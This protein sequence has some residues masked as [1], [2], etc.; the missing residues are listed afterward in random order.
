MA[1]IGVALSGGGHRAGLFGL[2]ALLY[3]ADAG[4]NRDVVTIS[5]VSGGSLTNA[6]VGLNLNYPVV[7][8]PEFR[9]AVRPLA[10]RLGRQGTVLA[11]WGTWAYLLVLLLALVGVVALWWLPLHWAWRL[12]VFIVAFG[13]WAK[14]VG[15][16]GRVAG[17][18][19]GA[20]LYRREGR[21]ARLREMNAGLDHVLCATEMHV[22]EHV[23]FSGGFVCA[24]E[25]GWGEPGDL[26]LHTAV[27][28]S[29]A[30]PGPFPI[31]WMSTK[32]FGFDKGRRKVSR[33]ALMDGGVYD[34]MADQ[35][36]QGVGARKRRW[37]PL[38]DGLGEPEE[39]VVVN[40]SA[41]LEWGPIAKAGVPV[42]GEIMGLLRAKDVLY[43][44]TTALRRW[45][46][47]GR[48]DRA[49]L[50]RRGLRGALVHIPRSP[51]EIATEFAAQTF[52]PQRA[53]RARAVL[54][55]LS[56]ED[57]VEWEQIAKDDSAVGTTLWGFGTEVSARLLR[58]AYVLAMANLH[59]ILDYP[60]LDVP[61]RESFEGMLG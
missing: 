44:N 37:A 55:H 30:L 42:L 43:D 33:V 20:T 48:F 24:Y 35:W 26:P 7:T 29:A 21:T 59:V 32:R 47:V 25:L 61:S 11:W 1:R 3:L 49:E 18:A 16:R 36:P 57:Q 9:E 53:E 22:G 4:K 38:A 23:Y 54:S 2:G 52:W 50:E 51:F 14:L 10:R 34:N 15:L 46:L 27:Q 39:L 13:L 17:L 45:G 58:H 5:S 31:S 6:F 8:G 12:G 28:A 40:A 41:P 60:L 19:F 56:G